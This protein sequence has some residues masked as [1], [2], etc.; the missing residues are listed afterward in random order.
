MEHLKLEENEMSNNN[1]NNFILTT[2]KNEIQDIEIK[3]TFEL[4]VLT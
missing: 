4:K 1:K 3:T 2:I